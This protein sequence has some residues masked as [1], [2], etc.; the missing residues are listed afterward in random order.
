MVVL[1]V[2]VIIQVTSFSLK[3]KIHSKTQSWHRLHILMKHKRWYSQICLCFYP[4]SE[5]QFWSFH[6]IDMNSLKLQNM[7][8][9]CILEKK[10]SQFGITWGWVKLLHCD[11]FIYHVFTYM[12]HRSILFFSFSESH[13]HFFH[14]TIYFLLIIFLCVYFWSNASHN[15]VLYQENK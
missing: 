10:K 6:C 12:H 1:C 11:Q 4:Y 13:E 3:E 9:F 14:I 15:K 5:S 7:Y 8:I 2:C